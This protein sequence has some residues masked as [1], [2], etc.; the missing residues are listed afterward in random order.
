M[1]Q[2]PIISRASALCGA[3]IG[4][5]QQIDLSRHAPLYAFVTSVALPKGCVAPVGQ[6]PVR[7]AA[8]AALDLQTARKLCLFEAIERYCMQFQEKDPETIQS[9]GLEGS[10][11][12]TLPIE[13][14]R[15][16]HPARQSGVPLDSRG[17]SIGSDLTDAAVRS[18]LELL[19]G[20]MVDRWKRD[21]GGQSRLVMPGSIASLGKTVDWLTRLGRTLEV[22]LIAHASGASVALSL[23]RDADGSKPVL[24]SAA[25]FDPEATVI[26]A[27][28]ESVVAWRNLM[29]IDLN[30]LMDE[31][32]SSAHAEILRLYRG[33]I[34]LPDWNSEEEDDS[35]EHQALPA[36]VK[37]GDMLEKLIRTMEQP[38]AIFDLTRPDVGIPVTRAVSLG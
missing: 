28:V 12:S 10:I 11:E 24:G 5:P 1:H 13:A 19:E 21:E 23:C 8:G 27:V 9:T 34:P 30:G 18:L 36:D 37:P 29:A 6:M 33:Q 3:L 17:C 31:D 4:E 26:R 16:G 14:L 35:E 20:T 32:L 7:V 38:V 15:L 22:R 2:D 25:G